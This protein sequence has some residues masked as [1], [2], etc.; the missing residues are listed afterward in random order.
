MAAAATPAGTAGR[1]LRTSTTAALLRSLVATRPATRRLLE[2]DP[3]A[4]VQ[5]PRV[6]QHSEARFVARQRGPRLPRHRADCRAGPDTR[7]ALVERALD[8]PRPQQLADL[9]AVHDLRC[10]R[11]LELRLPQPA[12]WVL[13]ALPRLRGNHGVVQELGLSSLVVLQVIPLRR[14][15][16]GDLVRV[17]HTEI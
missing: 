4:Q 12:Q 9:V 8:V 16:V 15:G 10:L 1:S 5:D 2:P 14:E 6:A 11:L 3:R 13:V 17:H 7:R